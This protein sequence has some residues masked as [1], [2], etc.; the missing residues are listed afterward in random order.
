MNILNKQDYRLFESLCMGTQ[1]SLLKV[2]QKFLKR[3]K[4]QVIATKDYV[5]GI[6]D[7]P[8][9]LIAH[10]DTV[11]KVPPVE[12]LYDREKNMII[13]PQLLGADDRAG[14]F[15][16]IKIVQ[17]GL[18]PHV[19][20]TTD[21]EIGCVGAYNLAMRK[22]PFNDCRF[23][24]QLDRHGANDCVFYDCDNPEFEEYIENFGFVKAFGSFTDITE[25][26]PAWG[27]AGVNLSIGYRDEHSVS[28][29]LFVGQMLETI[30]KVKNI[31]TEK[32]IPYFKYISKPYYYSNFMNDYNYNG[33]F[34]EEKVQCEKCGK[35][36][37]KDDTL[38][39]Y[40][41]DHKIKKFCSECLI[42]HAFI[43]NCCGQIYEVDPF[44]PQDEI[45]AKCSGEKI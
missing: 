8:I 32:T 3:Y 27:M 44:N 7:I 45:C 43:C 17:S 14:V 29:V 23:L 37:N 39:V 10:L 24:I 11:R 34:D 38:D 30:K 6:G 41:K 28:E 26:C 42:N 18:K 2:T 1:K 16:I 22:C 15:S 13:S 4:Y 40:T 21:E 19:I 20:F 12:I 35:I 31:L 36:V 33:F 9:A 5:I 25:L